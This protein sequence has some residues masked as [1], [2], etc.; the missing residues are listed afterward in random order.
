M[1]LANVPT[2]RT[3][4]KSDVTAVSEELILL[5]G[6]SDALLSNDSLVQVTPLF[7]EANNVPDVERANN[8]AGDAAT[9][10]FKLLFVATV[11]QLLPSVEL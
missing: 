6:R 11:L 4:Y 3:R 9:N 5:T 2:S 8:S 7:F 1:P 10:C